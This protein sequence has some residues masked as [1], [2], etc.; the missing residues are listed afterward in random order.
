MAIRP[1]AVLATAAAIGVLGVSG[2]QLASAQEN[3][4][5]STVVTDG[6]TVDNSTTDSTVADDSTTDDST[7]PQDDPNCP[8]MGS[9]SSGSSGTT[10][11][12]AGYHGGGAGIRAA[13]FRR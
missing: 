1:M 5:D 12:N 10:S 9:D 8:N 4:T 7:T 11:S 6:S 13:T 2:A 3:T